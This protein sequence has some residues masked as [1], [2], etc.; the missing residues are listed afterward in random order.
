MRSAGSEE[1][2]I[3]YRRS[4]YKEFLPK[5]REGLEASPCPYHIEILWTRDLILVCL[6]KGKLCGTPYMT[7]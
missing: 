7:A 3:S 5:P 4:D 6:D 1:E 2:F